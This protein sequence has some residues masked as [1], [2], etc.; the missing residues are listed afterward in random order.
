MAQP[1]LGLIFHGIGT[2]GR[3]L[4]PGEARYWLD[5]ARFD[6]IL[7]RIAASGQKDRIRISFDDGNLSDHEIALPRLL[8]RGLRADFFVLSGRIGRPGSLTAEQLRALLA[9]G[10]R[11]GSH[12]TTHRDWRRLAP[13]ALA[14][15]LGES[16]DALQALCGQPI[17][18]AGIPFGSYDGSVLRAIRQAGYLCAYSSDRGWMNE[19]R[20]LRP[21]TSL[22]E[23]MTDTEVT[24]VLAGTMGPLARLRRAVGMARRRF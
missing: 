23:D 4:E 11:V 12:G 1:A 24:A 15:E 18:A 8:A 10:M 3:D 13:A 7:D 14:R 19:D 16:R 21:R 2:P 22:R 5:T 9:V 17:A 20:F 6:E